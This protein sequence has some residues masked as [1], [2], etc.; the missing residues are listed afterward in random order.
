MKNKSR[1]TSLVELLIVLSILLIL[2]ALL[3]TGGCVNFSN[4]EGQKI[5]QVVKFSREGFVNDT[6]E[7]QIIRGGMN[8]GS[9]AF[10]TVP[11]D[12]TVEGNDLVNKVEKCMNE[13]TEVVI[14]YRIEGFYSPFRSKSRGHFLVSIESL[15]K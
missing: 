13:Q 7:G 3:S 1:G 6:W 9:G 12:F 4:G 15:K 11:F 2:L 5:G 14:R 10:G 8:Q